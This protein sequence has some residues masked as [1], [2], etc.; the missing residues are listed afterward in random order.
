MEK[1]Y[2]HN[3]ETEKINRKEETD[4]RNYH[5]RCVAECF[6][7]FHAGII[8]SAYGSTT[9]ISKPRR[10]WLRGARPRETAAVIY[11][12]KGVLFP[13]NIQLHIFYFK[14]I[15]LPGFWQRYTKIVGVCCRCTH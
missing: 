7:R 8:L 11:Y 15:V 2:F 1:N 4:Y 14:L 9:F 5:P 13:G 10:H 3:E 12:C 6:V